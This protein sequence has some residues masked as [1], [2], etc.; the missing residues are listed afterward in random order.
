[1]PVNYAGLTLLLVGIGFIIFEMYVSSFGI[2]AIGGIIAFILGSILL[3]DS[4]NPHYQLSSLLICLMSIVTIIFFFVITAFVVS[5]MRKKVV[6]GQE[7]L[8][9][10]E[11]TVTSVVHEQATVRVLG[12]IWQAQSTDALTT[13]EKI[14]VIGIKGLVLQV[15]LLNKKK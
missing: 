9:G 2:I 6:T 10:S 12:E 8:I 7:G 3:F 11:G 5:I 13:D 15:E 14:K 4:S 1:M